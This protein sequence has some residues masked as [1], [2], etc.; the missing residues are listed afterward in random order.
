MQG[1]L[2]K[3][4]LAFLLALV[5][6]LLFTTETAFAA[7]EETQ[8]LPLQVP[9]IYYGVV[10]TEEGEPVAGGVVKA[11]VGGE[12]CG[13]LPFT[14]GSYGMPEDDPSV[15]RLLVF[16]A[17]QDLSGCVVDFRVFKDGK[18]YTVATV[19]DQVKWESRNRQ[20][21]DMIMSRNPAPFIDIQGHW[22][23]QTVQ[24]LV[25][26]EIIN[27]YD[28][29]TFRP[30]NPISRAECATIMARALGLPSGSQAD[31]AGFR[32]ST[33][34]PI[35]AAGPVGAAVQV[36][37]IK[38]YPEEDGTITFQSDLPVTRVELAVIL[39]RVVK[40]KLGG[41]QPEE[42]AFTDWDNIPGW[43]Q[44]DVNTAVKLGLIK[45]YPDGAFKPSNNVT[46]AEATTM[47]DRLLEKI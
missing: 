36:G 24:Q 4:Y 42:T 11:Y 39:G 35:W 47:I 33:T 41:Q 15:K 22:A 31:L 2:K 25:D 32:D 29:Y 26:K 7:E 1:F 18:E 20:Q 44:D 19:P 30:E 14:G 34:I 13:S 10:N 21:V 12:L 9:A 38:G 37:L 8:P 17:T 46:R 45:G 5:L 3:D 23:G 27:G 16:S 43:A 40:G 28:D 6:V